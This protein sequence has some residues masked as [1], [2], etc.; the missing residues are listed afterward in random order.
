MI[1]KLNEIVLDGGEVADPPPPIDA[2]PI[3]A[4][5]LVDS[6]IVIRP[7]GADRP[8]GSVTVTCISNIPPA[9]TVGGEI[10]RVVV[11]GIRH[12]PT[13]AACA[14]TTTIPARPTAKAEATSCRSKRIN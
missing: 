3:T 12:V 9:T 2:G 1:A 7:L 5:P 11:L 8:V 13:A 6:E 4:I 10:I 14:G